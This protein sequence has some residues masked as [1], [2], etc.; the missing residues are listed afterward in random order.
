MDE[1]FCVALEY[2][3]PPTGGWGIGIDRLCMFLSNWWGH[4]SPSYLSLVIQ[5][6]Q[7]SVS[8]AQQHHQGGPSLP[9]HE[10]HH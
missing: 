7:V 8:L 10:A 5:E 6:T 4:R 2:G 1:D 9:G 3:L